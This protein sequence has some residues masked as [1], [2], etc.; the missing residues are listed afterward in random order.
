MKRTAHWLA[1]LVLAL[2]LAG[3]AWAAQRIDLTVSES[4][5]IARTNEVL[6]NGIPLP[7][8]LQLKS[9]DRLRVLDTN[10]TPVAAQ[11]TVLGRWHA[12]RSDDQAPIRWV[13][14]AF[15]ATV[16]ANGSAAYQLE[17]ADA[18]VSPV[19]PVHQLQLSQ[20]GNT[21]T[22]DTGAA[23]FDLGQNPSALFDEIR[24]SQGQL[25]SQGG[26]LGVQAGGQDYAASASTQV[27]VERSGPL[28]AV[29]V[30]EG[31]YAFPATGGGGLVSQRRY[32]FRAGSPV[33]QVRQVLTWQGDLCAQDGWDIACDWNAD[34]NEEP[35]GVKVSLSRDTLTLQLAGSVS[36]TVLGAMSQSTVSGV[37]SSGH[38]ARIEQLQ[39]STRTDASAFSASISGGGSL[40][41]QQADGG[42]ISAAG[43]NGTVAAAFNHMHRYEPAALELRNGN[44]LRIEPVSAHIW[45]GSRQGMF[46]HFSVGAFAAGAEI[47][48]IKA[49]LWAPLNFP[50]R[51]WPAPSGF[52]SAGTVGPLPVGTLPVELQGYDALLAQVMNVTMEKIDEKGISGAM[53]YGSFPRYWGIPLFGDELDC[54]ND[55]TPSEHWD[56]AY[57]CG[58]WTDYHN[59]TVAAAY[60]AMRSGAVRW[61]DEISAPAAERMLF[62]QIIQ[63]ADSDS[64]FYCG[65]AP[66]GYGGYRTDFNSSHGY[67]DNLLLYYWLTGDATV[68]ETLERGASSMRNYLCNRRPGSACVPTDP[69]VNEWAPL[70]GRA[71]MQWLAVFRFL[72]EASNDPS[73]RDDY[74]SGLERAVT[75]DYVE[76]ANNGSMVGMWIPSVF[77]GNGNYSSDQLWM[78]SLYDLYLLHKLEEETADREIGITA[79][80]PGRVLGRWAT[81]LLK[82]GSRLVG[83][84]TAEGTWPNALA[85]TFTGDRLSGEIS[86]VALATSEA[87]PN[88]WDTGKAAI[89]WVL[90]LE[91]ARTGN[92]EMRELALGLTKRAISVATLEGSPMG[93]TQGQYLE[94]LHEAVALLSSGAPESPTPAPTPVATPTPQPGASIVVSDGDCSEAG[95]NRGS[96]TVY[97]GTKN[98][99]IAS[100]RYKVSG[101][102]KNGVDVKKLNGVVR[103]KGSAASVRLDIIPIDDK[104][105]EKT[106][107]IRISLVKDRRYKL[108][109]PA[110]ASIII[111][112]ND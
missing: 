111:R 25:L 15:P 57:W 43:S 41:G 92:A 71:V 76:G 33:A 28:S 13:L 59:T 20:A 102:A 78:V 2:L 31:G 30:I 46:S 101:S 62:T 70:V 93:K 44:E 7:Q 14:V 9:I 54:G 36:G 26:A 68:V 27:R 105:R 106:E 52:S 104:K 5:G 38:S 42:I 103:F 109:R 23:A 50:L 61:L 21:I 12:A 58:T 108:G 3:G 37:I 74:V 87:D 99:K 90:A 10:G 75:Q 110:G 84:G 67:F 4:A 94:R 53:T 69:P 48:E 86:N 66:A 98:M 81:T 49:K 96:F 34:G 95:R 47:G 17:V 11:F 60:Y 91:A 63:C 107:S 19:T 82:L 45:L 55:P 24:N 32:Q 112:D 51:A 79:V 73:Y 16:A 80:R 39:R 56:D 22:I 85:F 6:E 88:L 40:S 77:N 89:A 18:A 65:Q 72:G 83:D 100:M 97:R 8:A 64:Y 35:N 1:V 29:V